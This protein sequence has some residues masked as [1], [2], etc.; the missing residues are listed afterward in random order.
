MEEEI[1]E[2]EGC[3]KQVCYRITY[4]VNEMEIKRGLRN[5]ILPTLMYGSKTCKSAAIR[6]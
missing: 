4:K 6:V 1:R 3:E 2:K 5:S